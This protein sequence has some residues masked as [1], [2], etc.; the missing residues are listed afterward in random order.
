MLYNRNNIFTYLN[1]KA[2]SI[3]NPKKYFK[4]KYI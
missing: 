4:I 1:I 2:S 3:I